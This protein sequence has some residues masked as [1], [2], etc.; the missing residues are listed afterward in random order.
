MLLRDTLAISIQ[1]DTH[2]VSLGNE[3]TAVM[4]DMFSFAA[5]SPFE[6]DNTDSSFLSI[7]KD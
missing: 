3:Y 4:A 2:V 7:G 1:Q 6:Q 5:S